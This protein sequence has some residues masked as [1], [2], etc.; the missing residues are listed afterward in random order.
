LIVLVNILPEMNPFLKAVAWLAGAIIFVWALFDAI[1]GLW[2][3]FNEYGPG[4]HAVLHHW[5]V[6]SPWR[7]TL[8][9]ALLSAF[10]VGGAFYL[11]AKRPPATSHPT[12]AADTITPENVESY[13][14]QWCAGMRKLR[15]EPM[16]PSP[17]SYFRY[18]IFLE[19]DDHREVVQVKRTK[20]HP[21]FLTFEA[22]LPF[23]DKVTSALN[24]LSEAQ[25]G[26]FR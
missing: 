16:P 19:G 1:R 4:V 8:S 9:V 23:G 24:S 3:T 6:S 5:W 13:V 17:L 7:A 14:R 12:V 15:V 11:F 18:A 25:K 20:D 10:L 22:A 26:V 21:R 2:Q